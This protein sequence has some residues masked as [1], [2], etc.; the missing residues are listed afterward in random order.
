MGH[1]AQ[2]QGVGPAGPARNTINTNKSKRDCHE[3]HLPTLQNPPPTHPRL[4]G[5]LQDEKRPQGSRPPPGQRPQVAVRLTDGADGAEP[6][7]AGAE[8]KEFGFGKER[9]L[10]K[11]AQFSAC[12]KGS[13]PVRL[14]CLK[15]HAIGN[16]LDGPRLGLAVSKKT[17]KRA[18]ARN[19]MKRRLREWFRLNQSRI[20]PRDVVI[21]TTKRFGRGEFSPIEAAL[22]AWVDG[23]TP[24]PRG[25]RGP[26]SERGAQ[27]PQAHPSA[28]P[29][30]APPSGPLKGGRR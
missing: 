22:N 11:P 2:A 19:Y 15:L 30:S 16:G 4:L 29:R 24:A 27:G 21:V 26:R 17:A 5:S 23:K 25:G 10:A 7:R 1:T 28:P 12:F 6:R 18:N 20:G 8:P 9:R 14:P 13:K 3:T